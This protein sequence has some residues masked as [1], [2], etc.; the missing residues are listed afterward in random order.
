[1]NV[2]GVLLKILRNLWLSLVELSNINAILL[3]PIPFEQIAYLKKTPFN[4]FL[5][6]FEEKF[7]VL[8]IIKYC[9]SPYI[10]TYIHIFKFIHIYIYIYINI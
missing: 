10:Y 2:I 6:I 1:M 3:K 4:L 5:W 9:F 8:V 7:H